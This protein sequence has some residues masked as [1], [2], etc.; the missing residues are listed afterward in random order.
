MLFKQHDKSSPL[1]STHYAI[2]Y[3]QNG[4]HIVATDFVTALHPIYSRMHLGDESE[5][6]DAR[7]AASLLVVVA[8]AR[9]QRAVAAVTTQQRQRRLHH[10][11]DLVVRE[12]PLAVQLVSVARLHLTTISVQQSSCYSNGTAPRTYTSPTATD[13]RRN[14]VGCF[15]G[16]HWCVQPWTS[17]Y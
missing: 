3:P 4:D 14:G 12:R 9:T 6:V 7:D 11:V 10:N 1:N 16:A 5:S 15:C 17:Q 13:Q 8:A 2:L